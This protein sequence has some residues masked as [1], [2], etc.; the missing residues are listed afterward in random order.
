MQ[1]SRERQHIKRQFSEL[2]GNIDKFLAVEGDFN[3]SCS[4]SKTKTNNH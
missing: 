4:Y 2:Q 3:M 1:K